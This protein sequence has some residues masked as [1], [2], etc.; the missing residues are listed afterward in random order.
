MISFNSSAPRFKSFVS[1]HIRVYP[2]GD[3]KIIMSPVDFK[4]RRDQTEIGPGTYQ[5]RDEVENYIKSKN[6]AIKQAPETLVFGSTE[7]R[8]K[9]DFLNQHKRQ[10]ATLE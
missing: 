7:T 1:H 4:V 10:L 8:A 5:S 3:G 9:N 2:A 6:Q